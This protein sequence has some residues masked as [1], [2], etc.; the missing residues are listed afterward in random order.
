MLEPELISRPLALSLS[1]WARWEREL[2]V[3]VKTSPT[4]NT[5]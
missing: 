4:G 2:F 3:L 1:R 5:Q